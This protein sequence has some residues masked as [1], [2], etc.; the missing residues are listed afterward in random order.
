[1]LDEVRT[2]LENDREV[3]TG[4]R[5]SC[6]VVQDHG[7][8]MIFAITRLSLW[9]AMAR[10]LGIEP[11]NAGGLFSKF[12]VGSVV[13][14]RMD[15]MAR[16]DYPHVRA[17]DGTQGSV[18]DQAAGSEPLMVLPAIAQ[19]MDQ[20]REGTRREDLGAIASGSALSGEGATRRSR[21]SRIREA[22]T[23]EGSCGGRP[24]P[25]GDVGVASSTPSGAC[26]N[27]GCS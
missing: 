26:V 9:L 27:P 14:A 21:R 3:C 8:P 10:S 15:K 24:R 23:V 17:H 16:G 18:D 11:L 2:H 13:P 5:R 12:K 22:R 6:R 4:T 19:R 7:Q 1:M 20:R 25:R